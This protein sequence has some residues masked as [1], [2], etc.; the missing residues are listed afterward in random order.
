MRP[1]GRLNR[2]QRTGEKC[3]VTVCPQCGSP[4]RTRKIVNGGPAS[5]TFAVSCLVFG[6]LLGFSGVLGG[7]KLTSMQ[8]DLAVS[9]LLILAGVVGMCLADREST[10]FYC[11]NCGWMNGE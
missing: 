8:W 2:H 5:V 6:G 10:Q 4:L 11:A 9:G 1:S 7:A 3:G